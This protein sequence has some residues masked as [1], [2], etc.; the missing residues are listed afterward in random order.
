MTC[1]RSRTLQR[2]SSNSGADGLEHFLM[3]K[4]LWIEWSAPPEPQ[5][6]ESPLVSLP[7]QEEKV[8][9]GEND[10]KTCGMAWDGSEW[11]ESKNV[12]R[13]TILVQVM[14][15]ESSLIVIVQE[16]ILLW[17]FWLTSFVPLCR[18]RIVEADNRCGPYIQLCQRK[19]K[20]MHHLQRRRT[21]HYITLH[22]K[23]ICSLLHH[24]VIIIICPQWRRSSLQFNM[25]EHA[26]GFLCSWLVGG[27]AEV[28]HHRPSNASSNKRISWENWCTEATA[29]SMPSHRKIMKKRLVWCEAVSH[30]CLDQF[31]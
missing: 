26:T 1:A 22:S 18:Q 8:A 27:R 23:A 15:G 20:I 6:G 12:L 24:L 31:S 21:L 29:C 3:R 19:R 11:K 9:G 5:K 7:P 28:H 2:Q 25:A 16:H 10:Q 13:T 30:S 17:L 4:S 14:Q